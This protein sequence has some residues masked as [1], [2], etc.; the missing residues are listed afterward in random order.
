ME[1]FG[2]KL[3]HQFPWAPAAKV[4]VGLALRR[5]YLSDPD[6][7]SKFNRRKQIMEV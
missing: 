3:A 6:A 5:R 1:Q 2:M 4:A 7:P